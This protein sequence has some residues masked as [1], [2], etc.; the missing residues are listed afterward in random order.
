MA[1]ARLDQEWTDG[2]GVTHPVGSIVE[3]DDKTLVRLV[4]AGVALE[5]P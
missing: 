2:D 5:E 3:V 4:R 1:R